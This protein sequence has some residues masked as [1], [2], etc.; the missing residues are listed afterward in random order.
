MR[1]EE[2]T[3]NVAASEEFIEELLADPELEAL[4]A[5]LEDPVTYDS[6]KINV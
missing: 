5:Q 6:D 4:P 2:M 3:A 1:W